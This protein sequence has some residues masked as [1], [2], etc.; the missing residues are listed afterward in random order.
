VPG[1]NGV[2][3]YYKSSKKHGGSRKSS[4]ARV[5]DFKINPLNISERKFSQQIYFL[6]YFFFTVSRFP[7]QCYSQVPFKPFAVIYAASI[8]S[9]LSI[10]T[11]Y[12]IFIFHFFFHFFFFYLCTHYYFYDSS[13]HFLI[14][15]RIPFKTDE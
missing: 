2:E 15:H 1:P 9:F 12:I 6:F 8:L 13:L 4:P 7:V 10:L 14:T 11:S 3:N 5:R